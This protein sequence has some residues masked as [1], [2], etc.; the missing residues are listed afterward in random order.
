MCC[1][2]LIEF[3]T[4]CAY[5]RAMKILR[6]LTSNQDGATIIEFAVVAPIFFFII[7]C[8][9]ELGLLL[10]SQVAL[11]SATMQV[12]RSASI[13][14]QSAGGAG[15]D[16]ASAVRELIRQRT[17]GLIN[18]ENI[19]VEANTL[20]AGGVQTQPELCGTNPPRAVATGACPAG[21][22]FQDTNNNGRYDGIGNVS[23][24]NAG[25]LVEIRVSYPWRIMIPMMEHVYGNNGL[26]MLSASTVIKNEPQ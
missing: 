3:K 14:N 25:D 19:V 1:Q 26:L 12:S 4:K 21:T 8:I 23:T 17:R 5:N 24:G 2:K 10:F 20:A 22:P 13:C 11:E 15:A 18:G 16:C 7:F 6:K 9:I